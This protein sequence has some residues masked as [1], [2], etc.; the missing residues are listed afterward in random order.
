MTR[1]G[2]A[3]ELEIR[4]LA[5]PL[6]Q[7]ILFFTRYFA[8][9]DTEVWVE[10]HHQRMPKPMEPRSLRTAILQLCPTIAYLTLNA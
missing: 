4:L 2:N 1:S 3:R 8:I 6:E 10:G 5:G 7:T 9:I